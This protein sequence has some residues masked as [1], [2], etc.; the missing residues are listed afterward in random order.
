MIGSW[1][2]KI[3]ASTASVM[4]M[5]QGLQQVRAQFKQNL[6]DAHIRR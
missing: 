2:G 4:D 3:P 5:A 6:V 1:V